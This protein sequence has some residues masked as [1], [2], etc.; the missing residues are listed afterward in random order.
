MNEAILVQEFRDNGV[1]LRSE[2]WLL[3]DR[4]EIMIVV[5]WPDGE[6]MSYIE[7]LEDEED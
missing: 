1:L 4:Q 3:E 5:I 6:M 7:P 2:S